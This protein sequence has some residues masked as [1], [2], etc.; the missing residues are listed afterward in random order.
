[1]N[2]H[3]L[4]DSDIDDLLRDAW[5]ADFTARKL[6]PWCERMGIISPD[7]DD[8]AAW[9]N[10]ELAQAHMGLAGSDSIHLIGR[11]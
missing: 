10:Y 6:G 2:I 11:Y 5:E 7:A 3:D 1:M 9:W 4:T 8:L